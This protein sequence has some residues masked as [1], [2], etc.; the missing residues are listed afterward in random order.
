MIAIDHRL[1]RLNL[2]LGIIEEPPHVVMQA[3]LVALE[4]HG[5]AALRIDALLS[6]GALAVE[7]LDGDGCAAQ[8]EQPQ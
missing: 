8:A 6:D 3:L 4:R 5:I 7:R 1:G 2:A